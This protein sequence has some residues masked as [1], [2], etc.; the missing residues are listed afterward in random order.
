MSGTDRGHSRNRSSGNVFSILSSPSPRGTPVMTPQ[1]QPQNRAG[2]SYSSVVNTKPT[3][4]ASKDHFLP[5]PMEIYFPP[6]ISKNNTSSPEILVYSRNGYVP[7][8]EPIV[9]PKS[10]ASVPSSASD[11][12]LDGTGKSLG[13]SSPNH[14]AGV[15]TPPSSRAELPIKK[16]LV[17]EKQLPASPPASRVVRNT[18]YDKRNSNLAAYLASESAREQSEEENDENVPKPAQ[19]VLPQTLESKKVDPD[20]AP[21]KSLT[22]PKRRSIISPKRLAF[23]SPARF[24]SNSS[25]T[26]EQDLSRLY[27]T[28]RHRES[29]GKEEEA[30]YMSNRFQIPH[31][32]GQNFDRMVSYEVGDDRNGRSP[33]ADYNRNTMPS[34]PMQ[35]K[36]A[37]SPDRYHSGLPLNH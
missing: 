32:P 21:T 25:V 12:S 2:V 11:F 30:K 6:K 23:V 28:Y 34:K 22:T 31:S 13:L 18:V 3:Y 17:E 29:P 16:E 10:P 35:Y 37:L 1:L 27:S 19:P 15:S 36:S 9:Q 20:Q 33:L 24:V 14:N 5:V 8:A 4:L 26:T 7:I